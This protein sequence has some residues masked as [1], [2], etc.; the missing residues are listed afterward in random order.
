MASV[1]EVVGSFHQHILD[2]DVTA[3]RQLPKR[4]LAALPALEGTHTHTH[5]HTTHTTCW[6]LSS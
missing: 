1:S 5:T 6:V 2:T 3:T 4:L